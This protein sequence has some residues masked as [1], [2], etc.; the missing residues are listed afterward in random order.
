MYATDRQTDVR[1]T[2]SLICPYPRGGGI[3]RNTYAIYFEPFMH[4]LFVRLSRSYNLTACSLFVLT[5]PNI[6]C[7]RNVIYSNKSI[8]ILPISMYHQRRVVC[9]GDWFGACRRAGVPSIH[10]EGPTM[11]LTGE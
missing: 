5:E 6:M 3:K 1:R 4:A 10:R 2:S 8:S 7:I 11:N 9:G